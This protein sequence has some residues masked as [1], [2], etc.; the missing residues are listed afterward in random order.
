MK[1]KYVITFGFVILPIVNL[2]NCTS[3]LYNDL[4]YGNISIYRSNILK[5]L[6]LYKIILNSKD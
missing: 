1:E 4:Q 2:K 5:S 3:D 6:S